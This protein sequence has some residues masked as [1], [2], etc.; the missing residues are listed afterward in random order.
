METNTLRD[1]ATEISSQ[2]INGWGNLMADAAAE[3]ERLRA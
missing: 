2:G 3:I 1:A